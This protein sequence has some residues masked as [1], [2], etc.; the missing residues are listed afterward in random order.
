MA[1]LRKFDERERIVNQRILVEGETKRN[2]KSAGN[3]AR[4][5]QS[6][7]PQS[8]LQCIDKRAY[9]AA[10]LGTQ[11]RHDDGDALVG[12]NL[13]TLPRPRRA[14]AQLVVFALEFDAVAL[15][16]CRQCGGENGLHGYTERSARCKIILLLRRG[17]IEA[18]G[19]EMAW[20]HFDPVMRIFLHRCR[21]NSG[22]YRRIN[23]IAFAAK[24]LKTLRPPQ[25]NLR[26]LKQCGTTHG[27]QQHPCLRDRPPRS[28]LPGRLRDTQQMAGHIRRTDHLLP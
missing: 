8:R 28:G 4:R 5:T 19:K 14:T 23:H 20:Q 27:R 6:T 17:D 1:I 18:C 11:I 9:D 15:R 13:Q 26:I 21:H 3:A 12:L 25:E 22:Q 7:C 10:A 2:I 16:I 24:L